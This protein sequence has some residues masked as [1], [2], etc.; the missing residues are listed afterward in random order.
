LEYEVV[1]MFHERDAEGVPQRWVTMMRQSLITHGPRFSA[2]RMV[3]DYISQ[4]YTR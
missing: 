2:S 4:V 1:P 3:K